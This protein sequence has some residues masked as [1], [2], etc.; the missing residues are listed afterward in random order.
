MTSVA[1]YFDSF[2]DEDSTKEKVILA[3][4]PHAKYT[5]WKQTVFYLN[6]KLEVK[7]ETVL[8]CSIKVKRAS[9]NIRGLQ[10]ILTINGKPQT[11]SIE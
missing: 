5:H 4:G 3:T 11:Y 1:G 8:K 10:V 2:F 9:K 6:E 7:K